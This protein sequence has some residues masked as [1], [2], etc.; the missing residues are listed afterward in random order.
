MIMASSASAASA[1][2]KRLF[3]TETA[4]A[5]S[6]CL[7][8]SSGNA[9]TRVAQ[10]VRAIYSGVSAP[11]L[12]VGL[13]QSLNFAVYDTTR[14]VLHQRRMTHE[15]MFSTSSSSSYLTN[16]ALSGVA[17]AGFV[18]GMTIAFLTAPL[19]MIKTNQQITGNSF[20]EAL[21]DSLYKNGRLCLTCTCA[22]GF[23]PHV[24]GESVGRAI[25][26]VTY[27]GLKRSWSSLKATNESSTAISLQ[28]RMVCAAMSG[29][30]CWAVIFPLDSLRSRVYGAAAAA[31]QQQSSSSS[32]SARS[33]LSD[34]MRQ[35]H[36][37]RS[38]YRGFW[39]TVLRAGPVAAAVL[40]VYDLTLEALSSFN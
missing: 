34:T 26:Y 36:Q 16:D 22:A 31:K 38:F 27:E 30:A 24:I 1:S 2:S 32:S 18:S 37:E 13:V 8:R 12:T 5:S 4:A 33:L 40:P 23:L 21:R 11:L 35:M 14:Q 3:S 9:C 15:D 29:I 28:E 17:T 25:Y 7:W 6:S 20:R 39:V 19:I 10:G